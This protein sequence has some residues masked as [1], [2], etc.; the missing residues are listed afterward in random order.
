MRRSRWR[1]PTQTPTRAVGPPGERPGG[2]PGR[3]VRHVLPGRRD[4]HVD[5]EHRRRD[6]PDGLGLS[7][8]ADEEH[9][10]HGDTLGAQ[11]VEPVGQA[12]EHA[13]DRGTRQVCRGRVREPQAVQRAGGVR[14]VRVRSPSRYGTSTSPPAPAG[15]ARARA[16]RPAWSTPSIRA[17]ASRTREALSVHASGRKAPVASAK[18]VTRPLGSAVGVAEIAETTPEVPIDSATSPSTMPRPSAAAALSPAPPPAR[19]RPG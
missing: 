10:A 18:P 2:L 16:L 8:A 17:A 15:A 11:R 4:H 6:P 19:P 14:P 13:L 9:P 1:C 12:A 3:A 5:P 7:A